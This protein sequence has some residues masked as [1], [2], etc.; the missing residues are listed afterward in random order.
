MQRYGNLSGNSGVVAFEAGADFIK[1]Q[2]KDGD[3]YTYTALSAGA[4]TVARMKQLAQAGRGLATFINTN[5][6]RYAQKG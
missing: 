1:V 6:P 3:T 4:Q 2:F 5:K